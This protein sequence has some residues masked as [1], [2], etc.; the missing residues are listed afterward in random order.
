LDGLEDQSALSL[1]ESNFRT[2][3]KEHI[4]GLLEAKRKILVAKKQDKMD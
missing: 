1:T 3:I 4:A 2:I